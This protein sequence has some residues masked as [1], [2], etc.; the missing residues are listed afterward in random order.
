MKLLTP[1]RLPGFKWTGIGIEPTRYDIN[2]QFYQ[3]IPELFPIELFDDNDAIPMDIEQRITITSPAQ[4]MAPEPTRMRE[5]EIG[6]R[7]A[8][9]ARG[10]GDKITRGRGDKIARGR[11]TLASKAKT[12]APSPEYICEQC[13]KTIQSMRFHPVMPWKQILRLDE[14]VPILHIH[15]DFL[16]CQLRDHTSYWRSRTAMIILF[17][18]SSHGYFL[19]KIP[20]EYSKIVP[21]DSRIFTED[22][23]SESFRHKY[24]RI[25]M[26]SEHIEVFM[27]ADEKLRI[28]PRG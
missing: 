7:D 9:I 22:M 2:E 8:K 10:R 14:L 24:I 19:E 5:S 25:R 16:F 17:H 23:L 18:M 4:S 3:S 20:K 28:Y 6:H 13:K 11:M 12:K 15:G 1:I 26:A 21:T 27:K